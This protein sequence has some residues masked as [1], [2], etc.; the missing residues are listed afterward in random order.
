MEVK[1]LLDYL[2]FI[3]DPLSDE[4]D[5]ALRCI[6]NIPNRYIG[7]MFINE[8]EGY[9]DRKGVR[10][11][12]GLKSMRIDVPYIRKNVRSFI[13]LIDPLIKDANKIGPSELIYLLREGLDYDSYITEDDV[14]SPDDSKIE[15][16]NQL[17]IVAN[18]YQNITAFLNYTDSFKDEKS[19]DVNGVSLMTIH[20]SKGLEF[21]VVFM[22]GVVEGVLPHKNGDIEEERRIAFVGL[23]RA[24]RLLYLTHSS[25]YMG[26]ASKRSTFLDE[27]QIN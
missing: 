16:I 27:I 4:G 14:P 19:N 11:Y 15:N 6:I 1:I 23:S 21:P 17:Q 18:K 8:L 10:F 25:K 12:Q 9:A 26:K 20:K 24:M 2:R 5:E 7:R 3:N 22:I 13:A